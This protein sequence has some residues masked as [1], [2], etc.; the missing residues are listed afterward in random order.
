MG[1]EKTIKLNFEWPRTANEYTKYGETR[2]R[3]RVMN[4]DK[5]PGRQCGDFDN[6]DWVVKLFS[7]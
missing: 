3:C 1:V 5:I 2:K 7:K 4:R 6:V